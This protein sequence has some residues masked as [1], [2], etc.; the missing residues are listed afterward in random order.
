MVAS[1][2][3]TEF[4]A[5]ASL[6]DHHVHGA[7]T[8]ELSRA[9]F[10]VALNEG[11]PDPVPAWM[12]QFD[13]QLGFA[14]RRW[15]APLLDLPA[16]ASAAEYWRRRT[17]L[18]TAE[19]TARF[20]RAAGVSDWVLDTGYAAG[21][22]LDAS[23]MAAASGGHVH[24]VVRL[25]SL[26]EGLAAEGVRDYV[27]EFASRLSG[28][29]VAAKSILAYRCGF[30]LDLGR[31]TDSEVA[32]AARRWT[33][34]AGDRPRLTDPVLIRHGLHA[35][36][37]AGLPLQIHTGFGDR[38]LDLH[39]SNPLLLLDFL[40]DPRVSRVPVLLLHCYPYHREAG[41]L[42]QAFPNVHF[43]VGLA[44]NHLGVRSAELIAESFELA[45]FAKQLYSSDAWGP[46]E[47]HFLGATLWRR[48]IGLI[49]GRWVADGDWSPADATRVA[50]MLGSG[51][52]R[53]V[54][55]LPTG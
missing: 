50:G 53:R 27:D 12:T 24:P 42:A 34:E 10:E 20:L 9:E 51:N 25:E 15:C 47:L 28:R 43:D 35:A 30:D 11:S 7:F 21:T 26:A 31:P 36:A 16:H 46:P 52:A 55:R 45:P 8:T 2:S 33:G 1:S 6:V 14:I 5:A 18:G 54:Y 22:V 41:Y 40:R 49:F 23:G 17:E 37:E 38:D 19:V 13:S 44:V 3:L 29:F 39:R 4:L 32:E 48:A